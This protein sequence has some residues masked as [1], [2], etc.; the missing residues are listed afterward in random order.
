M[1]HSLNRSPSMT[2]T[3]PQYLRLPLAQV[4]PSLTNPRKYYDPAK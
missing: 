3:T 4:E 2:D 1:A